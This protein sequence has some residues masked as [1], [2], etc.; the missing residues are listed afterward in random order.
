MNRLKNWG[1]GLIAGKV[2]RGAAEGKYG[3]AAEWLYRHTSGIKTIAGV[4]LAFAVGVLE[5]GQR[6]GLC[7]LLAA[8]YAWVNCGGWVDSVQGVAASVAGFFLWLGTVDG[9]LKLEPP[10]GTP[11][12]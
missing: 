1:V 3:A 7:D 6:V 4:A 12:R 2:L 5:V 8:Y 10:S 9:G 11:I